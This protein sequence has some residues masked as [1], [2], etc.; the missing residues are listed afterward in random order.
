MS[1]GEFH[2]AIEGYRREAERQQEL[3][4]WQSCLIANVWITKKSDRYTVEKLMGRKR[5]NHFESKEE[6]IAEMRRRAGDG[7]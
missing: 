3:I 5:K 1:Q 2:C 4:A 6:L 7:E